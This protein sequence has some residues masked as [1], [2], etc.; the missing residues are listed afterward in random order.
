MIFARRSL[1]R[2]LVIRSSA[3]ALA[4]LGLAVLEH[5]RR[6]GVELHYELDELTQK[7]AA[8]LAVV[9]GQPRLRPSP[10]LLQWFEAIPELRLVLVTKAEDPIFVWH[11][12]PGDK[13]F[14]LA[15]LHQDHYMLI[16]DSDPK[17]VR[18]GYVA[19]V[20][21]PDGQSLRLIAER[22][23]AEWRDRWIWA[24]AE[25]R[26]EYGPFIL[27][28]ALFSLL[29]MLLTV[30]KALRPLARASAAAAAIAPG[31]RR[32]L[33]E[34]GLPVEV[35]PLV[36]AVNGALVRFHE[37]LESQRRFT[38]DVAHTLR[39]PLAALRAQIEALE[40]SGDRD[41][42]LRPVARL[43]RLV[44]Q[45]LVRARLDSPPPEPAAPV[46]LGRVVTELV[47]DAAPGLLAQGLCPVVH[48]PDEP[49]LATVSRLAV[50]QALL[51]LVENAAKASKP[52]DEIELRLGPEGLVTIRDHGPGFPED[53]LAALR[54]ELPAS[55]P[56][57]WHGAGL[58]LSIVRKSVAAMGGE[59]VARNHP[60]GGAEIGF[61]L[62]RA[63]LRKPRASSSQ[64][65]GKTRV[66]VGQ[67]SAA[68]V[69]GVNRH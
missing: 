68:M 9:D 25:I 56:S 8:E 64:G 39:G 20:S 26:E 66:T 35:Q 42:L 3:V 2:S 1:A 34:R 12:E 19:T 49:L 40:P 45:L 69:S 43:D 48:V 63:V 44:G 41:R 13:V 33:E 24:D 30:R 14:D 37:A 54:G 7:I 17:R 52:G 10:D 16:R 59:L 11:A 6:D 67:G 18:F 47:A 57:R 62:P 36:Q 61:Q 5:F 60:E 4:A 27:S 29:V 31:E 32:T 15:Q 22:A 51:N 23:P 46:D 58:G 28:S 21:L 53:I 38:A 55:L 65:P 50:E